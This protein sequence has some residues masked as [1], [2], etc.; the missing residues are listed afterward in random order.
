MTK[1]AHNVV[2]E[3]EQL[4]ERAE[5]VRAKFLRANGWEYTS[6]TP[7]CYWMWCKVWRGKQWTYHNAKDALRAEAWIAEMGEDAPAGVVVD[8]H[9]TFSPAHPDGGGS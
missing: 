8:R 3:A 1:T 2:D 7:N 6:S 5:Q 9:Q 4:L